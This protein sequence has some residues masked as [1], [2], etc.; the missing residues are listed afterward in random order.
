MKRTRPLS[1]YFTDVRKKSGMSQW[2]LATSLGYTSPQMVSNWERD[3][4]SPPIEAVRKMTKL[5]RLSKDEVLNVFNREMQEK[6][7]IR[8]GAL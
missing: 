5:F 8:K 1:K 2:D 4:C 7:N 6:Y 3:L